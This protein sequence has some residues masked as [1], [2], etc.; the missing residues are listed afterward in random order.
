MWTY[1]TRLCLQIKIR[2]SHSCSRNWICRVVK[3]MCKHHFV[4]PVYFTVR[5]PNMYF[6]KWVALYIIPYNNVWNMNPVG[7]ILLTRWHFNDCP[8]FTILCVTLC[9][10]PPPAPPLTYLTYWVRNLIM[11]IILLWKFLYLKEN[12]IS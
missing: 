6:C 11:H 8:F 5:S 9:A 4:H 12:K 7:H 1:H 2:N 3:V 10:L